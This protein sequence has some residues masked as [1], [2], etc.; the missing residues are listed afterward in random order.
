MGFDYLVKDLK[1]LND[2]PDSDLFH[3]I[4]S[5]MLNILGFKFKGCWYEADVKRKRSPV[6]FTKLEDIHSSKHL[7]IKNIARREL[8]ERCNTYPLLEYV[9]STTHHSDIKSLLS[10][11]YFWSDL[12]SG[13]DLGMGSRVLH[14]FD[15]FTMFDKDNNSFETALKEGYLVYLGDKYFFYPPVL[16]EMCSNKIEK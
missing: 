10:S 11:N 14:V 12:M 15:T 3:R 9:I 13:S 2:A 1:S 16:Y 5:E 7:G 6:T 8:F 4:V